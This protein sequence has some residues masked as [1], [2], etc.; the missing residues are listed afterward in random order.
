MLIM[1]CFIGGF[2]FG[3]SK[4]DNKIDSV[5]LEQAVAEIQE[6]AAIEYN[7]TNMGKF[8]NSKEFYGYVIP[9]TTSKFIIS[10]DGTIKAGIE[11][12]KISI[13]VDDKQILVKLPNAEILSHEIDYDSLQIVDETYSIFN[14]LILTDYNQFYQDQSKVMEEKAIKKGLLD[15]AGQ[16][17]GSVVRALIERLTN[18][19]REIVIER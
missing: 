8:E 10:Y 1:A 9:F 3:R 14:P 2:I 18:G 11:L 13:S 7:Y 19:S 12:S 15:Q 4:A 5:T 6:L 16:H 17:A